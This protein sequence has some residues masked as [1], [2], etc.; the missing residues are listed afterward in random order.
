MR[1]Y[2]MGV[3]LK[4]ERT[5]NIIELAK[6]D[7]IANIEAIQHFALV[8]SSGLLWQRC[9]LSVDACLV[10][11]ERSNEKLGVSTRT[12]FK[13]S[14]KIPLLQQTTSRS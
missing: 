4:E 11:K 8:S 6:K 13:N 7:Q 2:R 10:L 3:V 9:A 1:E 12:C 14:F 5:G